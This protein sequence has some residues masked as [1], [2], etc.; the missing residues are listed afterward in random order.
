MWPVGGCV[1]EGVACGC[2]LGKGVP[3]SV[4]APLIF[5]VLLH[6]LPALNNNL[7][8]QTFSPSQLFSLQR[9]SLAVIST[10]FAC[11]VGAQVAAVERSVAEEA[12]VSLVCNMAP[13]G[14]R[15]RPSGGRGVRQHLAIVG[16]K[17]STE[18]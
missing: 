15:Q 6:T 10:G 14:D 2:G 3:T 12:S 13:V 16:T 5:F 4:G 9:S 11:E 17:I 7:C 8:L 1:V 18:G